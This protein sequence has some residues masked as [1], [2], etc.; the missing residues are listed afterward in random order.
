MVPWGKTLKGEDV[1]K[2]ASYV[3]TLQGTK[4][5]APKKAEGEIWEEE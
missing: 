5:A 3:L 1:Q 2:V 4:P